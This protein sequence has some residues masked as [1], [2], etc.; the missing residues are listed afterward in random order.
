MY[1]HLGYEETGTAAMPPEIPLK[2]PCH[3]ITMS[4]Q[5]P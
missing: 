4:K 2:I 1:Q 3:F 5:L